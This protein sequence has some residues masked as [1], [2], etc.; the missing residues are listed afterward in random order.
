MEK[1]TKREALEMSIKL[2]DYIAETGKA[3][4]HAIIDLGL[5][6]NMG[7]NCPAC[8]YAMQV[9]KGEST[10]KYCPIWT[11]TGDC[12]TDKPGT[13]NYKRWCWGDYSDRQKEAQAIA[14]LARLRL[15]Q[16]DARNER[17]R[18]KK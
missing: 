13:P 11:G 17:R 2:W 4:L 5:P 1:L 16:L 15:K 8:E 6:R 10:C 3:K 18:K 12:L 14:D 7:D 9:N